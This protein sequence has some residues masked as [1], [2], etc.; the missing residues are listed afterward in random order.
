VQGAVCYRAL[1][2]AAY[3]LGMVKAVVLIC[4]VILAF[5]LLIAVVHLVLA[6]AVPVLVIAIVALIALS[7]GRASGR[8]EN[9]Q[10]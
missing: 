8:R 4:A 6:I 2:C 5:Y 7:V 1:S 3:A 10:Q 9:K